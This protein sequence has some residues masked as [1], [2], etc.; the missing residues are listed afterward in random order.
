MKTDRIIPQLDTIAAISTPPG[1]GGVAVIRISGCDAIGVAEKCFRPRGKKAVKELADRTAIYG[2]ILSDGVCI[3][4]GILTL[5]RA[6]HSYTGEDTAEISCHGGRLIQTRVL[7]GLFA[8]GARPAGPGEFT[9]RA[10][11]SQRLALSEAE[12]I[13]ALIDAETDAQLRLCAKSSRSLLTNRLEEITGELLRILSVHFSDF[14]FPD[15]DP[16]DSSVKTTLKWLRAVRGEIDTLISTYPTGRAVSEGI[17]AVLLGRP[18]V[19]KSSI[20]NALVGEDA[21]IVTPLAGTTRDVLE[22]RISIGPVLVEL[23]DTA[24]IRESID[25]IEQIGVERSRTRLRDSDVQL[26]VLDRSEKLREEDLALLDLVKESGKTPILLLN[27]SDLPPA[28]SSDELSKSFSHII[29]CSAENGL[30]IDALRDLIVNLFCDSAL[31]IG[32]T[33]IVTTARQMASLRE[34]SDC[35]AEAIFDFANDVP[36]DAAVSGVER[37]LSA[38]MKTSGRLVTEELVDTIFSNFCV[39]K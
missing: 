4:D 32:E 27:K 24:G 9:R 16:V 6:P 33:A 25:P 10:V 30:G 7:E 34:A 5:F 17:R 2:D 26:V 12:A 22:R 13:G 35:L 28:F 8:A 15:E 1:K 3:D 21:A 20:Y 38:V 18:N 31:M 29:E 37:A 23:S 36:T 39:G 11:L 14:D 19:G